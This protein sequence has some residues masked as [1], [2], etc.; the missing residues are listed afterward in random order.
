[1]STEEELNSLYEQWRH[2]SVEEGRAIESAAWQ[3]VELYQMAK[4][5]LQPR[6]VEVSQRV[7]AQAYEDRFRRVVE[8]LMELEGRN[9]SLLRGQRDSVEAQR[10]ELDQCRRNLRQLHKSYVPPSRANWQSY[11]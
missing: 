9:A 4:S 7:D 1:M 10:Q 11:S 8:A 6:I 5:R 3:Q 2:L